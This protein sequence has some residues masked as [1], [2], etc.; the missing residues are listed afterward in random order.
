MLKSQSPLID[1]AR[2]VVVLVT[3]PT[4]TQ[5][6]LLLLCRWL[7]PSTVLMTSIHLGRPGWVDI[8]DWLNTEMITHK[9]ENGLVIQVALLVQP[10][11]RRQYSHF[12]I[13]STGKVRFIYIAPQ[14]RHMALSRRCGHRQSR[15]TV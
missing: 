15:R 1:C 11:V 6:L 13:Y 12:E 5:N 2:I 7:R 9:K 3:R 4:V 14:L 8:G 10:E